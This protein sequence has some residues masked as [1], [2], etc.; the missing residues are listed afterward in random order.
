MSI[1]LKIALF[2]TFLASVIMVIVLFFML[3]ISGTV[4]ETTTKNHL[5]FF[6][7]DNAEE[8]DWDDGKLELDD[9]NFYDNHMYTL[10]YAA[11]GEHLAGN[12]PNMKDFDQPLLH[13]N[14]HTYEMANGNFMTYD[15]FVESRRHGGVFLRGVVSLTEVSDTVETLFILTLVSLPFFILFSG[16]GSYFIS[17]KSMKPLEKIIETASD[18]S[19]GDD[20]SRR[21][22]LG[23]GRDE[24]HHLAQTFDL[25]F[26]QLEMAFQAEKQFSSDVSHELRTPVAVILAECECSLQGQTTPEEQYQSL[27]AI[28]RQGKKMQQLITALLNLIRLDNGVQK[29]D[30]QRVDLSELVLLVC[31][32]QESLLPLGKKI[33]TQVPD[34]LFCEVDYGMIIRVLSNLI[35]NAVKY[36]NDQGT[37]QVFLEYE[38]NAVILSVQDDGIGIS[39]HDLQQIFHRFYRVDSARTQEIG[40]SMG[41]G[42]A[43]VEQ[44][45][46]LHN[47]KILVESTLGQGTKFQVKLPVQH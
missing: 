19:H 38:E 26:S 10:V 16:V 42:L 3:S 20:L 40:Q 33:V 36:G 17:K 11:N 4:V 15:F 45:V 14:I 47:G 28:Q 22:N 29:A 30:F 37:I 31:E 8:I 44:M 7:H 21:I 35:D 6:V 5:T 23:N 27:E 12:M 13:G 2:N 39:E 9:V 25:M 34:S 43:M 32:E 18:I 41:L 46:K 24:M 1:K